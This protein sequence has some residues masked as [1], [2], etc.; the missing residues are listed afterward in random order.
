ME[1]QYVDKFYGVW[2]GKGVRDQMTLRNDIAEI[3]MN[4]IDNN[5][6]FFIS[7]KKTTLYKAVG[8]GGKNN[9]G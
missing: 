4:N 9:N 6:A 3:R 2:I 7:P 1:F 5:M 8:V